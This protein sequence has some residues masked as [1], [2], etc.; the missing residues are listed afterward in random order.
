MRIVVWNCNMALHEKYEHLLALAPDIAIIPECANITLMREKAPKFSPSSA[1]WIGDNRH[2][3]LGVFTFGAYRAE[4]S[5]AYEKSLPH[6]SPV[7]IEGPTQFNLLA[8]W[9][10][11]AHANSYEACQGPLM[12]AINTYRAFVE[13]GPTVVAGD[14]NDNVLWDKPK[15]LNNHG[16]NIAA[17]NAF[18]LCSAYHQS[19]GVN[20]G[21]EPEPT[22]Y[23][24]NRSLDG[25]RYHIDYCFVPNYWIDESLAVEVGHFQEW[26]GVGLS[27][28][29]PL[30][31][32]VN[33]HFPG[34]ERPSFDINE[35]G[36]DQ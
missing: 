31:V 12:R 35:S 30:V 2:K 8:V 16:T 9:A 10:C 23:W 27:D 11:H 18:G 36:I 7:R 24:R 33:P 6:I 32:D 3:G 34:H 17:L 1:I 20:Q 15:K 29:V 4:Q 25:P 14:F 19:R 21:L 5:D 13:D 26:V 22:L 28:H